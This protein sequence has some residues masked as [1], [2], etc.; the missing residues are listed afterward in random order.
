MFL[1]KNP[2]SCFIFKNTTTCTFKYFE[3]SDVIVVMKK[4]L[5]KVYLFLC[6]NS[7]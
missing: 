5:L 1:L 7:C 4:S 6:P 2:F 3:S